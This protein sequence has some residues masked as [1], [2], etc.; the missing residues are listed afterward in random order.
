MATSKLA[1]I[2]VIG[3]HRSGTT[4]LGRALAHHPEVAYW[5]EPRHVWSWGNN[6][7][8]DDRLTADDATIWIK[9]R[10]RRQ[11]SKFVEAAGRSRLAEK[12]P[13][14]CLRLPFIAEIF[15]EAKFVHIHRDG[16]AVMRSTSV[17]R[18]TRTP[19]PEWYAQRLLGTP[20]WEWPTLV[21]R[22]WR[23][24]G[25]RLRGK[26]MVF[27][28]PR[29]PGWRRWVKE[30]PRSIVLAKQW[31]YTIEPVLEYRDTV[32]G[33]NWLD[34]RY[35][36]LVQSPVA[37]AKEIQEFAGLRPSRSFDDHLAGVCDPHR[38]DRWREE[39]DPLEFEES[40][41]ILEPVL[42]R[43]GYSWS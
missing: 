21:P 23:T 36:E 26:E 42:E 17:V 24:L 10:I 3:T 18:Q 5:E 9:R 39:T 32:A 1:P 12:T 13:S 38:V 25:R 33:T 7:R 8:T 43:L 37:K 40:R 41:P 19:G 22:A 6:Y 11:F 15:P 28:G 16:R 30:D 4:L 29:P 35:D 27:W 34:L 31:R 14:N 2:F 20:F